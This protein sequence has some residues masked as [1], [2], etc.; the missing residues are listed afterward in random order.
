[1]STSKGRSWAEQHNSRNK[2][3]ESPKFTWEE[4]KES[5]NERFVDNN[6]NI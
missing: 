2:L 3:V 4:E 1:M 6:R 5:E